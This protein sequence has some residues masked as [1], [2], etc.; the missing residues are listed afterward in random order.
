VIGKG[1]EGRRT[2]SCYGSE[3]VKREF[4]DFEIWAAHC[5]YPWGAR[6]KGMLR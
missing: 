4:E 1:E 5:C 6:L 3:D 2:H